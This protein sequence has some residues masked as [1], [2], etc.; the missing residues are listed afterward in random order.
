[1]RLPL[2][3][4]SI[5]T[6]VANQVSS[7][8]LGASGVPIGTVHQDRRAAVAGRLGPVPTLLPLAVN[9]THPGMPARQFRFETVEDRTLFPQLVSVATLNS[10]LEAGG[11]S[12]Q[13]TLRWR[14]RLVRGDGARLEL[15]DIIASDAPLSELPTAI[16]AP[17]RFLAGNPFRRLELDSV[18]VEVASTPGRD[19]WTVR[20]AR[21]AS[22]SV[23]AGGT[24]RVR[25]ELEH[26]HGGRR[27]VTLEVPVPDELPDGRYVLWVGGGPE[28]TRMEAQRLPGRYRPTSLE[29][30]WNRFGT[31]RTA[32]Q[33]YATIVAMAPEVTRQGRDY[34]E[35]PVS[36]YA[37]L[38]GGQL[39]G[40]DARRGERVFLSELRVPQNGAVRGEQQLALVVDSRSP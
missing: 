33:L 7:F 20:N 1:V 30:A 25:V 22:A 40:D 24:A 17:L 35:L 26:W 3:T 9:I 5:V 13:N 32:D 23:R 8:K 19:Q 10:A 39:A 16:G 14:M 2:S 28:L 37:L 12:G 18:S 29:D 36:A 34:P 21:L 4:A 11:T 15:H 38:A 31:L 27:D 6:V